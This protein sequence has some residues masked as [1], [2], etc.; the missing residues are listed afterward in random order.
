MRGTPCD[1]HDQHRS[2]SC[3]L[4]RDDKRLLFSGHYEASAN[5]HS[6][7]H[8]ISGKHKDL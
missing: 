5:D 2:G 6:Q 3:R 8:R 7:W 4:P 1:L